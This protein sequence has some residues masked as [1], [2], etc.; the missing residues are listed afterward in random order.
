MTDRPNLPRRASLELLR[1]EAADELSVLIEERIRD[2]EDPWDFMEDLPS[3]DELV[4]LTL[5]AENI[6]A[7]GGKRPT[8][9]RNYRVL[10]QIA[11][12]HPALTRAVW[13][14]LGSEPHRRWDATVRAEA[15]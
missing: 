15:S 1:A 7:D 14:L 5:R 6:A 13:R 2:G 10:R 8:A 4:V 12:E 11:L 9:A 3:V